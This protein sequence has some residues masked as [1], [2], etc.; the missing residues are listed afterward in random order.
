MT[1]EKGKCLVCGKEIAKPCEHCNTAWQHNQFYTH[2]DLKLSTGSKMTVAVCTDCAK[3]SVWSAD[4][5][6]MMDA[7]K[8][9]WDKAGGKYDKELQFV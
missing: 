7:I 9:E 1:A 3:S 6:Q 5:K 8:S 4:K 2:V